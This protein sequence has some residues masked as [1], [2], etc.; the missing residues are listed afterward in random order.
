MRV[1]ACVWWLTVFVRCLPFVVR[2][3]M[4]RFFL[5]V[6]VC[7]CGCFCLSVLVRFVCD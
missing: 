7:L 6:F 2:S 5:C 4:I 3:C 1:C